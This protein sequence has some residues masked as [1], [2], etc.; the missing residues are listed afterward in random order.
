[1]TKKYENTTG[2]VNFIPEE[3]ARSSTANPDLSSHAKFEDSPRAPSN[4]RYLTHQCW[5]EMPQKLGE[6]NYAE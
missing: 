4:V 2:Y 6:K 1:M 5:R 3:G